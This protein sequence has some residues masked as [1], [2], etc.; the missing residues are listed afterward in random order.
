[1]VFNFAAENQFCKIMR[2]TFA[3]ILLSMIGLTAQAQAGLNR[4]QFS[5]FW[6][7]ESEA[8]DYKVSFSGDTCEILSQKGLTLWRKEK[9]QQGTT[10]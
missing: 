4:Q 9:L 5:K 7:I 1:M 8:P 2:I 3:I 10:V 6:R